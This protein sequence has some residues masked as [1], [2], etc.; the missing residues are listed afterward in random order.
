MNRSGEQLW[1]IGAATYPSNKVW[2]QLKSHSIFRYLKQEQPDE[3][4]VERLAEGFAVTPDVILRVLRNKFVPPPERKAK[5]DAKVTAGLGQQALASGAT[6]VED[7]LKLTGNQ[8]PA[9]L[10]PGKA[11]GLVADQTLMLQDQSTGSLARAPLTV[12]NTQIKGEIRKDASVMRS[13][14]EDTTTDTELTNQEEASWDGWVWTEEEL[15]EFMDMENPS[16][17]VQV[18]KDFFDAEGNFLYRI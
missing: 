11:G 9:T 5:Q 6:P 10:P 13:T 4:T 2:F 16:P 18:G 8:T 17:V 1:G 12:L 15:V 14:E 3:W 7:R